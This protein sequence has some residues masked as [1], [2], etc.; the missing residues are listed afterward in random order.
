LMIRLME[1]LFIKQPEA[2]TVQS[3]TRETVQHNFLVR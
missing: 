3:Y 1:R 2:T